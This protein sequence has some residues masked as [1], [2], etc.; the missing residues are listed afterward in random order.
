M[1][2]LKGRTSF[3]SHRILPAPLHHCPSHP[4][5]LG[6]HC[7]PSWVQCTTE[8]RRLRLGSSSLDPEL[9]L[10]RPSR[11][12]CSSECC[13]HHNPSHLGLRLHTGFHRSDSVLATKGQGQLSI[14]TGLKAGGR[15]GG[16]MREKGI[17][18]SRCQRSKRVES[19]QQRS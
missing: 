9:P 17:V 16:R 1:R 5:P 8:Q 15:V 14:V 12:V 4:V 18:G 7:R 11:A 6:C 10:H 3:P 2:P 13:S 19:V